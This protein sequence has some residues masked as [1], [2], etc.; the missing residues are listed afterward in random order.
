MTKKEYKE[1][2]EKMT[3]EKGGKPKQCI[4]LLDYLWNHDYITRNMGMTELGIANVPEIVRRLRDD[5]NV[6]VDMT[7]VTGMNRYDDNVRYGEY[8]I[9]RR[10]R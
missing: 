3:K 10:R 6:P 4:L 8:S 9:A 2:R 5:Y 1:I 7:W